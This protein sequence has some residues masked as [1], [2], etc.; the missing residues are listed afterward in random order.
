MPRPTPFIITP[1]NDFLTLNP[2]LSDLTE[3][4]V[5]TYESRIKPVDDIQLQAVGT[6]LWE[7]LKLGDA[8]DKEKQKAGQQALP[9][10]IE[11]ENAAVQALPWE[12]LYH[13]G[14][15]IFLGRS[16]GFTLS[17]RSSGPQPDLPEPECGPLRVLLFTSL[18][19][20]LE[21][22]ERLDVE[23]E[24]AA[25]QEA[26][27]E[28]EQ[29]GQIVLEMPDDGRFETLQSWLQKFKPHLVYL[30]GHG[31]FTHEHH[32]DRAWGS[33][34]FENRTGRKKSIPEDQIS[35]CFQNTGVQL[36]V[37]SACLSAKNHPDYP[38]NG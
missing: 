23:A 13:P 25:V 11:S 38:Q 4:L 12:T 34:L 20:D 8:L 15:K 22:N 35:E 16:A 36:L 19:D 31:Q 27:L 2:V 17:R 21:E 33:F 28:N 14:Q 26:L 6:A 1:P 24:Q 32:N 30:S 7:A 10:I 37:I 18:P 9:I 3:R 5:Q 29:K